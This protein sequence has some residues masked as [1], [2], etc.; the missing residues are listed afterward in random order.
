MPFFLA[1]LVLLSLL[2][3][4]FVLQMSFSILFKR[5][6]VLSSLI[7]TTPSRSFVFLGA[8]CGSPYIVF[9]STFG[10]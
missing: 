9:I 5:L 1:S 2:E 4:D 6:S 3:D 7:V 10:M 8:A